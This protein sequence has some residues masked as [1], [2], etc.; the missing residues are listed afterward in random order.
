MLSQVRDAPCSLFKDSWIPYL[1]PVVKAGES[2]QLARQEVC[3]GG[4]INGI[5][6]YFLEPFGS[7]EESE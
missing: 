4:E 7:S 1:Y 3:I 6:K 2:K 5:K